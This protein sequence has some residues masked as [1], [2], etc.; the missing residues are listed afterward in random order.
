LVTSHG[1]RFAHAHYPPGILAPTTVFY[2]EELLA[3][4]WGLSAFVL[5]SEKMRHQ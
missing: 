5:F 2:F 1:T 3:L 4:N